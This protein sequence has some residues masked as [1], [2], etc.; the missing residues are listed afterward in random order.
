M[1][2][3]IWRATAAVLGI[4]IFIGPA[5][6]QTPGLPAKPLKI[7]VP[8]PPG[9]AADI[10]CRHLQQPLAEVLGQPV[11]VENKSG[12]GGLVGSEAIARSP[13]DGSTIGMV[14]SSHASNTA[15]HAKLPY[16]TV[17]DFKPITILVRAPNVLGVHPSAPYHSVADL[18]AAAKAQ[19]GKLHYASSG[20]GTA[21]HLGLE[22]VKIVAG[23]DIVHVPYRGAGPALNDLVSGQV[24]VGVLNIAGMLPH[25][26]AG[27]I[28]G[29]AVTSPKRSALAPDVPS[30]AETVPGFDFTEWFAL[31]A[32]AAVPDEVVGKLYAA[33]AQAA[34]TPVFQGKIRE[35]GM[36]LDL[37][38]PAEFRALINSEITKFAELVAKA[39]IKLD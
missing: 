27:H 2:R 28:R 30:M 13:A 8:W 39:N 12:A 26:Q 25:L 23:V 35:A 22:H 5:A 38:S 14:I 20:N 4:S 9:G 7:I 21:Q 3:W 37:N 6:A 1:T 29:L 16:D 19:P 31:L 18:I 10:A 34:R 32:P 24:Q 17:K 36:E 33:I 15:L 11:V